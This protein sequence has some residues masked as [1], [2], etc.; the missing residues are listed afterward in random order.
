[1][2]KFFF[3]LGAFALAWIIW[4]ISQRFKNVRRTPRVEKS[5]ADKPVAMIQCP[6]CGAHFPE[7]E[8]VL[9]G[10][11]TYCSERCRTQARKSRNR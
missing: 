7:D 4:K 8:A 3:W 2:N 6:V 9:S 1:M 5:S 10:K 11:K